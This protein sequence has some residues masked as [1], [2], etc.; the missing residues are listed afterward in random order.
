M[1]NPGRSCT[2]RIEQ[3]GGPRSRQVAPSRR[4]IDPARSI[5]YGVLL[6]DEP[7]FTNG[8]S[9]MGRNSADLGIGS[10]LR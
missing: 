6:D 2:G 7:A 8:D 9:H 3:F 5:R 10:R 4:V 1:V